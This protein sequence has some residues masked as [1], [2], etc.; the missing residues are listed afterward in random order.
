MRFVGAAAIGV[1]ADVGVAAVSPEAKA[2]LEIEL[3]GSVGKTFGSW[4]FPT[5]HFCTRVMYE[6][7]GIF[8][9]RPFSSQVYVNL[10]GIMSFTQNEGHIIRTH[11]PADMVGQEESLQ[12]AEPVFVSTSCITCIIPV[13]SLFISTTVVGQ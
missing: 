2:A 5:I 10:R 3:G 8:A 6:G 1:V 9:G 4:I 11:R 7:A 12:I 13:S